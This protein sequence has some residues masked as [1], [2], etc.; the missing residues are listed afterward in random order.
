MRITSIWMW[1][2][3]TYLQSPITAEHISMKCK[4]EYTQKYR[5]SPLIVHRCPLPIPQTPSFVNGRVRTIPATA[6]PPSNPERDDPQLTSNSL[7]HCPCRPH[8]QKPCLLVPLFIDTHT[9]MNH[10]CTS[11][12][13]LVILVFGVHSASSL[14]PLTSI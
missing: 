10:M 14:T 3:P 7:V 2:K 6:T 1:C 4:R 12:L 13:N 11:L 8:N 9:T 5:I